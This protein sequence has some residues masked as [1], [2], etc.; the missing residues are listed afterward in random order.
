MIFKE[1]NL[2]MEQI[3][4]IMLL[5]KDQVITQVVQVKLGVKMVE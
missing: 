1:R 5:N 4:I 3:G 2:I